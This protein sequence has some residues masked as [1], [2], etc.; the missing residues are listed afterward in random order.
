[1]DLAADY[2]Q[3]VVDQAIQALSD[4]ASGFV[5]AL[6]LGNVY[7]LSTHTL[8]QALSQGSISGLAGLFS[9]DSGEGAL[10]SSNIY[11]EAPDTEAL[12]PDNIYQDQSPPETPPLTDTDSVYNDKLV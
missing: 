11:S 7:D 10:E 12:E 8:S 2:P 1:M 6:L 9:G 4:K 5:N 3:A